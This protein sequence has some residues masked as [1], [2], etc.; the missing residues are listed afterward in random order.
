MSPCPV[1]LWPSQ[2]IEDQFLFLFSHL[3]MFTQCPFPQIETLEIFG[4]HTLSNTKL[5][6]SRILIG[7]ILHFIFYFH[8]QTPVLDFPALPQPP[9]LPPPAPLNQVHLPFSSSFSLHSPNLHCSQAS[10]LTE[11]LHK[12]GPLQPPLL[13]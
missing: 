12:E 5:S 8:L 11:F 7:L 13:G 6:L 3:I 1:H 9:S 2:R 10:V 4:L